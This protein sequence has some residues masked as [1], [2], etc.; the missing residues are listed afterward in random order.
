MHGS[1]LVAV[2][3]TIWGGVFAVVVEVVELEL[4]LVVDEDVVEGAVVVEGWAD[5]G[6]TV[7][8]TVGRV[9]GATVVVGSLVEGGTVEDAVVTGSE[10]VGEATALL[11]AR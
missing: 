11:V 2:N 6:G 10:S 9:V 5:V 7:M 3:V 1:V 4:E 8:T